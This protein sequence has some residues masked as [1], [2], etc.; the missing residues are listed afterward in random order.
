MKPRPPRS[1]STD[2]LFPYTTLFRSEHQRAPAAERAIEPR[3]RSRPHRQRGDACEDQRIDPQI[4]DEPQMVP[5]RHDDPRQ[6]AE[7]EIIGQPEMEI[8]RKSTRLNSSH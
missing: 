2:T 5:R 4:G 8:D 3:L 6:R 1:N 7:A